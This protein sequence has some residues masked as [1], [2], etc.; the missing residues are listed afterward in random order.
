MEAVCPANA[1]QCSDCNATARC[2][3]DRSQFQKAFCPTL[4]HSMDS[5]IAGCGEAPVEPDMRMAWLSDCYRPHCGSLAQ[6][7]DLLKPVL[8]HCLAQKNQTVCDEDPVCN[9]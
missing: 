3:A 7:L 6:F 9:W 8:I 4:S 1:T 2:I 5:M